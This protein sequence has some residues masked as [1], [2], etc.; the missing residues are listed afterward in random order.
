[1]F[2]RRSGGTETLRSFV[3]SSTADVC[4][5]VA[6]GCC[7]PGLR[8]SLGG[9]GVSARVWGGGSILPHGATFRQYQHPH[10][11]H[12]PHQP[13]QPHTATLTRP[14]PI[15]WAHTRHSQPRPNQRRHAHTWGRVCMCLFLD[16]RINNI[17]Q[18]IK[19]KI[20]VPSSILLSLFETKMLY[21]QNSKPDTSLYLL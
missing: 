15:Q 18:T 10:P 4:C 17:K 19:H 14:Q 2:T 7:V 16:Q 8:S 3:S 6:G 21:L 1:M 11:P 9:C 13:H 12:Q 5:T 20:L